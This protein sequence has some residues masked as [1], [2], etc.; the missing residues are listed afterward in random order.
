MAPIL[1]RARL[2]KSAGALAQ[3]LCKGEEL[4]GLSPAGAYLVICLVCQAFNGPY[5]DN[6]HLRLDDEDLLQWFVEWQEKFAP[7]KDKTAI[8][9]VY[10]ELIGS[11]LTMNEPQALEIDVGGLPKALCALYFDYVA[12]TGG[13]DEDQLFVLLDLA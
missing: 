1:Q 12:R 3:L 7:R 5:G 13:C 4:R 11:Y 6:R 9:N 2:L 8:E 10:G